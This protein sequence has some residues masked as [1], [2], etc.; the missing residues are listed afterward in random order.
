MLNLLII[1]A[2]GRWD[3]IWR[4]KGQAHMNAGSSRAFVVSC[5]TIS[6]N[7]RSNHGGLSTMNTKNGND[8]KK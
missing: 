6:P 5:D 3:L 1:L 4:L 7:G 8:D 2:N